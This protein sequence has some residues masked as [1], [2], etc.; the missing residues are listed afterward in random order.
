MGWLDNLVSLEEL[1]LMCGAARSKMNT[2]ESQFSALF[3]A[4]KHTQ[5]LLGMMH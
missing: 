4:G 5:V 3:M 1:L 2:L